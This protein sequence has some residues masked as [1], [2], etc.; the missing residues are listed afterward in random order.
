VTEQKM[1]SQK[2]SKWRVVKLG[3]KSGNPPPQKT[4]PL[5]E[6]VDS[7]PEFF[8]IYICM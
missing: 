7:I 3:A 2:L 4:P 6:G 8:K 1:E 5:Y